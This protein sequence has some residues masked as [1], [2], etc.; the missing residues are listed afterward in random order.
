VAALHSL[1]GA[2]KLA[3]S[4]ALVWQCCVSSLVCG[5]V[6]CRLGTNELDGA[7]EPGDCTSTNSGPSFLQKQCMIELVG[8]NARHFDYQVAWPCIMSWR[9][10]ESKVVALP[11][12]LMSE[13]NAFWTWWVFNCSRKLR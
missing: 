5:L 1:E 6:C 3:K 9:P 8:I 2:Q 10:R 12:I 7:S 4:E 13:Q 11:S